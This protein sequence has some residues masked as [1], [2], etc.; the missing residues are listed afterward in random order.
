MR[1]KKTWLL[2]LLLMLTQGICCAQDFYYEPGFDLGHYTPFSDKHKYIADYLHY[3]LDLRIGKGHQGLLIGYTHHTLDSV[4]YYTHDGN[5]YG[6]IGDCFSLA[7]FVDHSIFKGKRWSFDYGIIYGADLWTRHGNEMLGSALNFHVSFDLGPTIRLNE[8]LDAAIRYGYY[9]SSNGATFLPDNGINSHFLRLALRYHPHGRTE[10]YQPETQ[11]F[12]KKNSLMLSAGLGWLQTYTRLEGQLP[13]ETPFF[14]G[15]TFRIGF[16]R[17]FHPRFR[18]DVALD[19]LWTG[20]TRYRY[21]LLGETYHPWNATHL[22]ASADIEVLFGR[23]AFCAGAAYYL[24]H[25]IYSGTNEHKS[26]GK[27][28]AFEKN[29]LPEFYTSYYERVGYKFYLGKNRN[30]YVG[31]FMK[32][33]LNSIDYI[34]WTVGAL[35]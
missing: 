13:N 19:F 30:F 3:G 33:H 34:E 9:H 17:Q 4:I 20:E 15:N 14:F 2:A 10:P 35:L 24:Y 25:G 16:A 31:T 11:A 5:R 8:H 12:E 32:I 23:F 7:Y 21:E 26:W 6:P 28:T 29:H 18:W 27:L 22:A 1:N